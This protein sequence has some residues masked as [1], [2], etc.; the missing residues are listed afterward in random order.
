MA[1]LCQRKLKD[2]SETADIPAERYESG[3]RTAN[4][5]PPPKSASVPPNS[6]NPVDVAPGG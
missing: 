6:S 2:R 5:T 1:C 4:S 3:L